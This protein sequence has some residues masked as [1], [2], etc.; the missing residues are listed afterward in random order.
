M[1]VTSIECAQPTG[2]LTANPIGAISF[3]CRSMPG[4]VAGDAFSSGHDDRLILGPAAASAG[5]RLLAVSWVPQSPPGNSASDMD[6]R[7]VEFEYPRENWHTRADASLGTAEEDS[8]TSGA[9]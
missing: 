1:V 6:V 5:C 4:E 7:R 9:V 8:M 3:P 2:N